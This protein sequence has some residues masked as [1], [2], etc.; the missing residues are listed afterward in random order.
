AGV[1]GGPTGEP[2]ASPAGDN[3]NIEGPASLKHLNHLC[4]VLGQNDDW[5]L[6]P[7]QGAPVTFEWACLFILAEDAV[8]GN[9]ASQPL[10]QPIEIGRHCR[11]GDM[12]A[13][14]TLTYGYVAV[15]LL[16]DALYSRPRRDDF[17]GVENIVWVE[18]TLQGSHEIKRIPTVLRFH[19]AHFVEANTVLARARSTHLDG[20]L[21]QASVERL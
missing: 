6:L 8:C 2:G 3:R 5:R 14:Q 12:S 4:F 21:H 19:K 10:K 20:S 13:H 7:E 17:P 9:A 16:G 18:G 1:R 15:F 11:M